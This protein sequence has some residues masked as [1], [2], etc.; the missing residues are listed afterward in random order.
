MDEI[1]PRAIAATLDPEAIYERFRTPVLRFAL[2]RLRNRD[3]AED[4]MQETLRRVIEA[5]SEERIREPA[6]IAGFVYQTAKNVYF[7]GLRK[8]GNEERAMTRFANPDGDVSEDRP[9][10][11]ALQDERRDRVREAIAEL[12]A[13]ERN[14][15]ER[16]YGQGMKPREIARVMGMTPGAVRVRKHRALKRLGDKLGD[17][18]FWPLGELD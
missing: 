17:E 4:L 13:D 2:Q 12:E 10:T 6:A 14:L 18:T 15:L 1:R 5:V 8:R 9:L 3:D 16:L 7:S 11:T